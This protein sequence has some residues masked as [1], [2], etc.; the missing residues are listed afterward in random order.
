[1]DG[2][3]RYQ[4]IRIRRIVHDRTDP[5]ENFRGINLKIKRERIERLYNRATSFV[6]SLFD[7]ITDSKRRISPLQAAIS[8]GG[9]DIA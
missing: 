4:C 3:Y 7:R 1:M 6:V 8:H 9:L 5:S 2:D